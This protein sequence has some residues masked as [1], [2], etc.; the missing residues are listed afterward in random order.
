MGCIIKIH[1]LEMII[2]WVEIRVL[3]QKYLRLSHTNYHII[4]KGKVMIQA[5]SPHALI[6]WCFADLHAYLLTIV[7]HRAE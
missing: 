2:Q 3:T 6:S 5:P 7:E 1:E 4:I